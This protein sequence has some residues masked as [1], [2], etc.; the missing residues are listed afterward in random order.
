M[1][2]PADSERSLT[3]DCVVTHHLNTFASGVARFNEL[4]AERMGVPLMGLFDDALGE[5]RCPLLSFKVG[6]L[7]EGERS[8][9]AELL[10][11]RLGHMQLYLHD[12]RGLPLEEELV[13]R[14]GRV[15]CGNREVLEA[16]SAHHPQPETAW[17][18]GLLMDQRAFRPVEISVFSF[19][20][21]HKIQTDRFRRL[22][23]LLE[24]TRRSYAVY[25]SSANHETA[26]IRD[27][28]LVFEEMHQI[29]PEGLYFM[30]NL[31]DVAIYN[32]LQGTTF[33]AAFFP[34]GARANNTSV[35]SAMEQGCVVITNLD[36]HSP[37]ELEHMDNV[38]DLSR[39]DELP[40]D[41]L[42]LKRLSVRAM[43]T[44]RSLSWEA[45]VA[46]IS[47]SDA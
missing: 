45:L 24:R 25:V 14:A 38:I 31:S 12:W 6:E 18:P 3:A 43:E 32:Y 39:C 17:T 44:A 46:R 5:Y 1:R 8:S 28:H 19:G 30:G 21:A 22:R 33:F 41:P 20:M 37:P 9:L 34:N 13:R 47:G 16:V 7:D 42:V 29:F 36:E 26:S 4:L 15:F 27:A 40:S 23:E 35:A 10:H 11:S 2:P